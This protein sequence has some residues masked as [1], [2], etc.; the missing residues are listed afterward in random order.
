[1]ENI[2]ICLSSEIVVPHWQIQIGVKLSHLMFSSYLE[3]K[4]TRI[5]MQF[6]SRNMTK[7]LVNIVFF[8]GFCSVGAPVKF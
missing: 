5:E 8:F 6:F 2:T 3:K 7:I 4:N 1:M